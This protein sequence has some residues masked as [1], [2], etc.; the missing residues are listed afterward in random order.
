VLSVTMKK[1]GAS[2][3]KVAEFWKFGLA[4][5]FCFI[6]VYFC[7]ISREASWGPGNTEM[8]KSNNK[9]SDYWLS[10]GFQKWYLTVHTNTDSPNLNYALVRV[11]SSSFFHLRN[12]VKL[13]LQASEIAT[14]IDKKNILNKLCFLTK[15]IIKTFENTSFYISFS[16]YLL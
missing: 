9:P 6:L 12:L 11:K 16:T 13:S 5:R 2:S 4:V 1:N 3:R 8:R 7:W 10:I 15:F 14:G